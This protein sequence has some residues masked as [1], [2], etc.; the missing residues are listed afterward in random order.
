MNFK[1]SLWGKKICDKSYVGFIL[2]PDIYTWG[3]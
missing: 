2:N 3:K 1:L